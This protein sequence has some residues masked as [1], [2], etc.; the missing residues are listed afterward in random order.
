M[1]ALEKIAY[2]KGLMEGLKLDKDSK[3][4]KLFTA[5]IDALDII[6]EE[7]EEVKDDVFDL[8]EYAEAMDEDLYD[9]EEA[10]FDDDCDFGDYAEFDCP[11]CGETICLEEEDFGKDS[12]IC[13]CC[14]KEIFLDDVCGDECCD[15]D[16][17][18]SEEDADAEASEEEEEKPEPPAEL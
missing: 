14:G 17:C 16:E 10:V 6:A 3:E 11:E 1:T 8:N 2:I 4:T 9:V 7:I 18:C 15:C 12:V 5:I 13:P